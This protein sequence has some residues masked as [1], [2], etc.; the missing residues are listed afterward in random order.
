MTLLSSRLSQQLSLT[1]S[2]NDSELVYQEDANLVTSIAGIVC[3]P[4][5]FTLLTVVVCV[6]R[7]YKTTFQRL[8]LYHILIVLLCECSFALQIQI[9]LPGPRWMCVAVIYLYLYS[10][11][12]WYV[13]TA[14]VTSYLFVL[15]LRLLRANPKI[16]QHGKL[17]ECVCICLSLALPMAYVWMPIHDGTYEVLNCDKVSLN[18]LN[19]DETILNIAVLVLCLEILTVSLTLSS[20]FCYL[21]QLYKAHQQLTLWLK[22]FM[23]HTGISGVVVGFVT[24]MLT[25]CLYRYYRHPSKSFSETFYIIGAI[26]EPLTF[27]LS[28]IFQT[29]LSIRHQNGRYYAFVKNAARPSQK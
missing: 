10:V 1:L 3:A 5:V 29:L 25:Y 9:N 2:N 20:L 13:Y 22:H 6:Y 21:R 16:W 15:T 26:V 8:M 4:I 27:F 17:A 11:L 12:S 28:V 24:L 23:Y 7:A 19:K 14:A 18:R